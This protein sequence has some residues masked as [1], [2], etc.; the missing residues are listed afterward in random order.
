MAWPVFSEYS[1][2]LLDPAQTLREFG[3][4]TQRLPIAQTDQGRDGLQVSEGHAYHARS[5]GR[6]RR[7]R[8]SGMDSPTLR[9][10]PDK[11]VP[12]KAVSE[13]CARR[14]RRSG[15]DNPTL[16]S[17]PDKRVPPGGGPDKGVPPKQTPCR[18]LWKDIQRPTLKPGLGLGT[19]SRPGSLSR[20]MACQNSRRRCHRKLC[21]AAA[22]DLVIG[23]AK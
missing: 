14:A 16:R 20:S 6:A 11:R 8:R 21:R 9:S 7:A 10:G 18:A 3:Q 17:G 22:L 19:D 4:Y 5:E 15:M 2:R 1:E 13:G 23:P 12:P